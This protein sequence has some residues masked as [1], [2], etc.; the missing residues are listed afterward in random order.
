MKKLLS[1]LAFAGIMAACNNADDAAGN[2]S[3]DESSA[4]ST[5]SFADSIADLQQPADSISA[6][7]PAD[8]AVDNTKEAAKQ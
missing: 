1:I 3:T 8:S 4:G 2:K 6:V 5:K 7:Q